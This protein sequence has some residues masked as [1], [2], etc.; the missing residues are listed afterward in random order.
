MV[1]SISPHC[2]CQMVEIHLELQATL[3][4]YLHHQLAAD[5]AIELHHM[6]GNSQTQLVVD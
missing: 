3:S 6:E 5:F 4:A 2:G 1:G